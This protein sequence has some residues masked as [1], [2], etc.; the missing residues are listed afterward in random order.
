MPLPFIIYILGMLGVSF[1]S[2]VIGL[3][4]IQIVTKKGK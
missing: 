1:G 3:A 4:M 2:V